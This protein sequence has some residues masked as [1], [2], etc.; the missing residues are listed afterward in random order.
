MSILSSLYSFDALNRMQATNTATNGN[1]MLDLRVI[2]TELLPRIE[3]LKAVVITDAEG[4][5]LIKVTAGD[6]EEDA[7]VESVITPSFL[8]TATAAAEQSCKLGTGANTAAIIA[9]EK[10]QVV[11]TVASPLMIH[12]VSAASSNTGL[13]LD[14]ARDLKTTIAPLQAKMAAESQ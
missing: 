7:A 6:E 8:V 12:L 4:V 1:A 14:M 11:H 9:F 5:S 13:L 10:F 3:G 2:L